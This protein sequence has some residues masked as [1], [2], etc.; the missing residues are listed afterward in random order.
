[1]STKLGGFIYALD[2]RISDQARAMAVG[3]ADKGSVLV[4]CVPTLQC[5][6]VARSGGSFKVRTDFI[7][8]T[9]GRPRDAIFAVKMT[10][11]CGSSLEAVLALLS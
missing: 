9:F 6:N 3:I 4:D 10:W 11:I 5:C 2:H 8:T 1:M 7:R